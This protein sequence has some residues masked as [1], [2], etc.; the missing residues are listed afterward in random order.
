MSQH[1]ARHRSWELSGAGTLLFKKTT[2]RQ[3]Q[4]PARLLQPRTAGGCGLA[5]GSQRGKKQPLKKCP[6]VCWHPGAEIT[7][8]PAPSRLS[9]SALCV[10]RPL[11]AATLVF[12]QFR[13]WQAGTC[14]WAGLA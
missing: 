9:A 7:S 4:V 2:G 5:Q 13:E 3:M 8:G 1:S 11:V 14:T 10:E 6:G 12:L